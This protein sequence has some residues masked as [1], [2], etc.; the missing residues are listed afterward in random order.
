[1][2]YEIVAKLSSAFDVRSTNAGS[3]QTKVKGPCG[4]PADQS[5]E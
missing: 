5:S 1:M 3:P 4:R 2:A